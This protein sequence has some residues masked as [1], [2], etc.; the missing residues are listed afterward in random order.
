M[1]YVLAT[2]LLLIMLSGCQ[3]RYRYP[4]QDPNNA[5]LEECSKQACE[6]TKECPERK[7]K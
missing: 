6:I 3:D 1:K 5:H 2:C 4:C 7:G